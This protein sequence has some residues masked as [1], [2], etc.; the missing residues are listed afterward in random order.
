MWFW[1][2]QMVNGKKQSQVST[3]SSSNRPVF[4]FQPLLQIRNESIRVWQLWQQ[5]AMAHGQDNKASGSSKK[6][7]AISFSLAAHRAQD[8]CSEAAIEKFGRTCGISPTRGRE[9]LNMDDVPVSNLSYCL[10]RF[11]GTKKRF[12]AWKSTRSIRTPP[13]PQDQVHNQGLGT[14]DRPFTDPYYDLHPADDVDSTSSNRIAGQPTPI[15]STST[16]SRNE[17]ASILQRYKKTMR[18][19]FSVW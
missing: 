8:L 12:V 13:I 15:Q 14:Y 2:V 18:R 3:T 17:S 11:M 5:A 1:N 19:R 4:G 6:Y 7:V 10:V 16:N 9:E